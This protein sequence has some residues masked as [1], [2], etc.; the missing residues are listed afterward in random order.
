MRRRR[1]LL[2]GHS[3]TIRRSAL[4]D[5]GRLREWPQYSFALYLVPDPRGPVSPRGSIWIRSAK[6]LTFPLRRYQLLRRTKSSGCDKKQRSSQHS[7]HVLPAEDEAVLINRPGGNVTGISYMNSELSAKRL[8][9]LHELLPPV[10]RF[11]V[12][13]NPDRPRSASVVVQLRAA[14]STIGA[15]VVVLG[16]RSSREIDIAFASFV[17]DRIGGLLT[18]TEGLFLDRQVQILTLAGSYAAFC[19]RGTLANH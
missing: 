11:A 8:G 2:G 9:L 5:P 19:S 3:G 7:V 6:I 12:L 14:A 16:A 18:D 1:E 10:T 17:Q 15:Q 13:V 4:P